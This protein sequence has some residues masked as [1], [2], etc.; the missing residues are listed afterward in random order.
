[1]PVSEPK[2]TTIDINGHSCRVWTKGTGPKIGWL[3]GFGG[4]PRWTP[5]LDELAKTRTVIAPSLPGTPGATG[6]NLLD[7]HLDWIV[8]V[9]Q[10]I[11]KAGLEG[12]DLAGS[13]V[14][15]SFVAEFA[16][17][18]PHKVKR[19]ALIA[20]F[21]L[22]DEADP[23]EDPWAQ[24]P[25]NQPG[26]LVAN[27][28]I[29]L[30]YKAPPDGANSVEWPIEMVRAT[31]AAA[32]VFWPLGNTRLEKRLPLILAPTLIL[33]GEQDRLVPRSYA[34]KIAD[35]IPGDTRIQTI[36]GAGHLAELDQPVAT[37]KAI[38]DFMG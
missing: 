10:L 19:A 26:M 21:G 18:W 27:P 20:P 1:M 17:L 28:Q 36:A 6:H 4:L 31:E 2:T 38:L 23:P 33:W 37:A 9:R 30:D 8:A 24:R 5:F 22:Y 7:T 12:E 13:S 34:K 15:G 25:D 35:A 14:G 16:A 32:R 3:A 11:V 29:W